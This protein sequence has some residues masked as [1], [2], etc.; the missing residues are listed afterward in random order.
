MAELDPATLPLVANHDNSFNM[1]AL[2]DGVAQDLSNKTM[3]ASIKYTGA[4]SP[5]ALT[6][7]SGL[8]ITEAATGKFKL[9][10]T[11]AEIAAMTLDAAVYCY[12][13][14]WNADNS[15]WA[16]GKFPMVKTLG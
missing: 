9:S 7:A 2:V 3:T 6:L 15:A 1:Q 5:L 11:T 8:A 13:T 12:L 16:W 14:I 4:G 10:L